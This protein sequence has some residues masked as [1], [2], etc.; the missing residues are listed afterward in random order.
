MDV[1]PPVNNEEA[2]QP[3]AEDKP[4]VTGDVPADEDKP[5]EAA[6]E[7]AVEDSQ[8]KDAEPQAS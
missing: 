4:P 2:A 7:P 8:P 1:E 5:A 3:E 6:P